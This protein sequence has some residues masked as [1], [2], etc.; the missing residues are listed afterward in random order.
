VADWAARAAAW[1]KAG[2]PVGLVTQLAV[3]GSTPREAGVRMVVGAEEAFGTIGGGALERQA[4]DQ[5]RRLM[6]LADSAY[7]VQDYPLGPLLNQCCGGRVR[8]L[9]ERLEP[10]DVDWLEAAADSGA[11]W[12]VTQVLADRLERS[13]EAFAEPAPKPLARGDKPKPGDRLVDPLGGV[14]PALQLFGAGHVGK[15]TAPILATLPFRLAWMDTRPGE[16]AETLTEA[17]MIDR[18]EAADPQ[19][20]F[21]VMTH[22]HDLDY[23]L[24]RSVLRRGDAAWIGLIGSATKRARFASRL[25]A[26]GL[27]AD[28]VRCPIGIAGIRS[29]APEAIAISVAAELLQRLEAP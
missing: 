29:K 20:W 17:Q 10:K 18:I 26:E 15:A 27:S 5:A 7:A 19:S 1:L 28:P 22:S 6:A 8:L 14:R 24:I 23:A 3:E 9:I 12:L 25:K 16:G 2:G 21:L 11:G 4:L 13:V